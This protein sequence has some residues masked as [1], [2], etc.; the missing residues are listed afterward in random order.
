M[1]KMELRM[2]KCLSCHD[3]RFCVVRWGPECRRQGG[4]KIPRMKSGLANQ[5]RN[6]ETHL[7]KK[8][9]NRPMT[10]RF[11]PIRTKAANWR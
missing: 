2:G 10:E 8:A 5:K 1:R 3:L 11:E 6:V 7:N 9:A 4:K